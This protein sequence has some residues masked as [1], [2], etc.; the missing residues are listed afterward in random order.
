M[1]SKIFFFLQR[2]RN[3]I[4]T[5]WWNLTGRWL[6]HLY[7]VV[8]EGAPTLY[9]YPIVAVK[10]N[11]QITLG[12]GVVLCSDARFTALGVSCP[13]VLRAL[14]PNA[15]ISIGSNTGLSGTVICS[16]LSVEIG[17]DCLLGADVQ[18]FDTDFHKIAAENRRYDSSDDVVKCAPVTIEDNVFIGAGTKVLKG[19]RIGRNSVIGAGSVVTKDIPGNSIAAGNPARVIGQL[20]D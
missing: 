20:A 4:L 10:P 12:K 6:L 3:A 13:T 11:C 16:A 7:G 8:M 5:R 19:V 15:R 2:A 9:G 14:R 17:A 18:I 1:Y